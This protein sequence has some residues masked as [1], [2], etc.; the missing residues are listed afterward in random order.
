MKMFSEFFSKRWFSTIRMKLGIT[1][2]LLIGVISIFISVY[3]PARQ[4]KQALDAMDAKARSIVDMTAFSLSSA[5]YFEDSTGIDEALE[6]AKQNRDLVYIVVLNDSGRVLSSINADKAET[7]DLAL[8]K[9]YPYISP[10]GKIYEVMTPILIKGKQIGRLYLGLSLEELRSSVA[11]SQAVIALVGLLIFIVGVIAVFGIS[12]ILTRPLSRMVETVKQISKGDLSQRAIIT[13]QDEVGLLARSFN[14]M[15][16]NLEST[17]S[18]L[19]N[20]NQNL[21]KRVEERTRDLQQEVEERKRTEQNLAESERKYR[22]LH[23][24]SPILSFIIG[25]DGSIKEINQSALRMLGYSKDEVVGKPALEFIIPEHREKAMLDL[26]RDFKG[27]FTSEIDYD[28]YAKDGSIRTLLFSPGQLRLTEKGQV[29]GVLITAIDVTERKKVTKALQQQQQEQQILLDY[30]PAMIF[31]KDTQNRFIRVN[32]ALA[33]AT[34]IPIEKIEGIPCADVFPALSEEYWQDDRKVI[35]SGQPKRNIIE[36]LETANGI[37]WLQTDKIPYRDEKGNIIGIVGF[38]VDITERKQTEEALK[39]SEEKYRTLLET[40]DTGFCIVDAQGNILDAN[41]EYVRLSG[42]STLE[43]ILGRSVIEWTAKYDLQRNAEEVKKC[44][45]QGYVRNLEIDY[46]DKTGKTTPIE[47]NAT[48]IQTERG[49][50]VLT[51]CRD[52]T[53]RRQTEEALKESEEKYRNLIENQGEGV[54]IADTEE[55]FI[56]ANPAADRIFGV[57]P[58]G[59]IGRSLSEL[60]TP[61]QFTIIREQTKKR[62]EGVKSSYEVE[63]LSLDGAKRFLLITGAPHYDQNGT[64]D[65]TFGVLRDITDRKQAEERLL[66]SEKKYRDLVENIGDV[67]YSSDAEGKL[68]YVSPAIKSLTDYDPQ[69]LIGQVFLKLVHPDDLPRVMQEIQEI[70]KGSPIRSEVRIIKKSGEFCWISVSN[71]P[72]FE[73]DKLIGLRGILTDITQRKQAEDELKNRESFLEAVIDNIPNMLFVKDA[74]DLQFVRFNKAGEDLLG[75]SRNDMIG[76]S[77]HDF[78]PEAEADFFTNKDKD[79]L[80]KGNLIDI[81]EELIQTKH[82]G[83]RL[84]HTRKIPI[85]DQY[86]HPQYL[87]GISEDITERKQAEEELIRL[88]NAVRMST[89]SIVISDLDGK[90]IEINEATLK[91]YGTNDRNDLIGREYIELIDS[92]DRQKMLVNTQEA[93]KEG[94]VENREYQVLTKIGSRVSIELSASVMKDQNGKPMGF[95]STIRDITDRKRREEAVLVRQKRLI[96]INEIAIEVAGMKDLGPVLQNIIDRTRELIGAELGVV[97]LVDPDTHSI[98]Q[99]FPSNYPTDLIPPD[100]ILRGQGILGKI[101]SGEIIFTEDVTKEDGY[102]GYAGWHPTIHAMIGIPLKYAGKIHAISLL[103]HTDKQARFSTDD[104]NLTLTFANIAAVAIHTAR[105]FENLRQARTE[106]EQANRMKSEFLANMSHEIRTPMN[107]VIGMTGITLDTDLTHEQRE[108]LDIVKESAY[109]LLGLLDDI[110]DFSKIEAGKVDLETIDF[111]LRTVVEGVADTLSHR[112][113]TKGVELAYMIHR[114]VPV[115]LRGDPVRLRQILMNLGGNAIKFTEKGEVVIRSELKEE[116]SNSVT[117]LFSVTD[118]GLG[119]PLDK[120]TSIFE[121]FTQLDGSTT[122]KYGGTGLGLSISKR[123]VEL[124]GGHIGIESQPGEGSRFWFTISLD[125]QKEPKEVPSLIPF[126]LRE[127][128][129][130]VVDDNQTNRTILIK[131]L[132]SFGCAP[133]AV[134]S[135]AEALKVLSKATRQK[136]PFDL[137][138]L[139]MQMPEMNGEQTLQAIKKDPKIKDVAVIVLTSVGV[140]GEVARLEA[141]GCAGYLLKPVKQSQLFDTIITVLNQR[142]V[143]KEGGVMPI[144]TRHIIAEHKFREAHILVAED[145]PTNMKLAVTLLSRAGYTVDAV[146]NG[147]MVIEALKKIQYDLVFMDVQMPEMDGFEAT[148]IIREMEG[149][150]KHTPIIAMTAHAM[151]GDRERCLKAGMD[152]YVSKPIEPQEMFKAIEEWTKPTDKKD[153]TLPVNE[154]KKGEL[155]KDLPLDME[156]ALKRFDGDK[157]F[158]AEL[159][160]EFLGSLPKHLQ[161][162]NEAEK[163]GDVKL[164]ERE[165]HSI[166]GAAGNLGANDLADSALKLEILG[167]NG[168]LENAKKFITEFEDEIKRLEDYVHQS[169]GV[170]IA[171]KS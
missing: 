113:S 165:A 26:E 2:T 128:R 124:M 93:L 162:L 103:G 28:L 141:M 136:Q 6:G 163:K 115:F 158:F 83:K 105:Q 146:E 50:R 109:S 125:K 84:L 21:E 81:P 89:D 87:L 88:S 135:G 140:R 68:D 53:A 132:E 55:R 1:I 102:I 119:I 40:T 147:K 67:I 10:D 11:R 92:E 49:P 94:H 13:S 37:R 43:E 46:V 54:V 19:E 74:Q 17:Y 57:S 117:I 167:R 72:V 8:S 149:E 22:F 35:D 131:M 123:L 97:V 139:D 143:K 51:L 118:T 42:H 104:L 76:K 30:V 98:G 3:F 86:G 134:G 70:L 77:D 14:L 90:I 9:T 45:L 166:K 111:D 106:A 142:K 80:A 25:T 62:T 36:P 65:G 133:E 137:A 144:V 64:F 59:L 148:R 159:M 100:T 69:E 164:I 157:G 96:A 161:I 56:F 31:Y 66:E 75:Y 78:F 52:I 122:R 5:L 154:P 63:I 12:T 58:G 73:K 47:I 110:L 160:L 155:M 7:Q 61:D 71:R 33:E 48:V 82:K 120:Q 150:G 95:V 15:V 79:V 129:I 116:T 4:Q 60:T 145:N 152:D 126:N 169:L 151:K 44:M 108:Y 121:S 16:D 27:E 18:K 130:L 34:G 114:E 24:G 127:K 153:S 99:A 112:A 156:A 170:E 85:L 138:L 171:V 20:I 41:P 29:T 32:R 23:E 91:M 101:A 168:E 39:E 38:S 107:A